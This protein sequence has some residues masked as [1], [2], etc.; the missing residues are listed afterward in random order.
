MNAKDLE[1]KVKAEAVEETVDTAATEEAVETTAEETVENETAESVE[2]T[3]S[4]ETEEGQEEGSEK[5]GFF[6]KKE[7]KDKK[8]EK[9]EELN[10]RLVRQ[11]AEF[12][13]FR[14]RSEREKSQMFEIGAKDIVEKILP[15]IDN[16]E[17]GLA[18]VSPE[19]LESDAFAQGMEKVYKHFMTV[20]E[21]AGVKPIE[22]VGCEFNPDF[23]N[24]VMHVEDEEAGENIV[25]EEFQKGYMY[26]ESVVRHSMV[27]VAN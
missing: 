2:E 26:K 11:M 4:E 13:N 21:Q 10:D 25:V 16:M 14:K 23:H 20:L 8:D 7:K 19:V 17:R 27:K 6:K 3:T 22:A 24:A 15:V 18:T 12:D 5:K 1:N 9:I